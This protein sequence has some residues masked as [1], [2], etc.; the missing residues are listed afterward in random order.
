[1]ECCISALMITGCMRSMPILVN[2]GGPFLL[3]G[4]E[5]LPTVVNGVLYIGSVTT[6]YMLSMPDWSTEWT[7]AT[8]SAVV[9]R[10]R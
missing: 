3:G 6:T 7:F 5:S 2:R 9:L 4:G 8:G 1:M 10:Q